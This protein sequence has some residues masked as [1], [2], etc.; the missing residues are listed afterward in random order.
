MIKLGFFFQNS[1]KHKSFVC[2]QFKC[3]AVLFNPLIGPYQVLP[4]WARMNLGAMA[5]KGYS[6]FLKAPALLEPHHQTV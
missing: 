5:M 3:Q 2:T 6:T 1:L 4:L